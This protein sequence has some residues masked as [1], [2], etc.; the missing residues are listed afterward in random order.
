MSARAG[1]ATDALAPGRRA[2]YLMTR[3]RMVV[4][5]SAG[6]LAV[7]ERTGCRGRYPLARI[8]RVISTRHVDWRGEALTACFTAGIGIVFVDGRG[9]WYGS[10]APAL[11]RPSPMSELLEELVTDSRWWATFDNFMRHLRSRIL[12]AWLADHP[13]MDAAEEVA[14]RRC[15]VYR[16]Q[17]PIALGFDYR[18]L[19]RAL[20]EAHLHANAVRVRYRNEDGTEL[21]LAA[22]LSDLVY[23][24]LV[25]EAGT[26]Q[27][28]ARNADAAI[29]FFESAEADHVQVL[30]QALASLRRLL[31]N[32]S[33]RWQ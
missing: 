32:R 10:C 12:L 21:D 31:L 3:R 2:L 6:S 22:H 23:G 8:S 11:V 27:H 14:W 26:L 15:Y 28:A 9:A 1:S 19:V 24:R 25:L 17:V 18:G 33:R 16:G 5:T 13:G 29:R 20:V 7:F 30:E 4:R